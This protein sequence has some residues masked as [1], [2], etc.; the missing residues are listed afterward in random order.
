MYASWE[1]SAQGFSEAAEVNP[2]SND[3]KTPYRS[4]E[5][6]SMNGVVVSIPSVSVSL[7]ATSSTSNFLFGDVVSVSVCFTYDLVPGGPVLDGILR[8]S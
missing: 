6:N 3:S 5:S 2:L 7:L 1:D 8:P 4:F